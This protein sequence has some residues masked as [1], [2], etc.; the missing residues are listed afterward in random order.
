MPMRDGSQVTAMGLARRRTGLR[1]QVAE[2]L[3]VAD[4]KQS[5]LLILIATK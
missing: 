4:R 5:E 1:A 2:A 3:R